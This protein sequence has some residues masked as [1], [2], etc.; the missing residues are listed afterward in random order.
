M[1]ADARRA[2]AVVATEANTAPI[3]MNL[4]TDA[5]KYYFIQMRESFF[6]LMQNPVWAGQ[7]EENYRKAKGILH[8]IPI[9]QWLKDFLED[10]YGYENLTIVPNGINTNM[11]YP[12]PAFPKKPDK[13]RVLIEGFGSSE[14]KDVHMM[15]YRAVD[16][17]RKVRPGTIELWG[18][19]QG[20]CYGDFDR[21][22][23]W[24]DQDLI[25]Q[26][27]SSSDVLITCKT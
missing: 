13:K 14:A 27:Y 16:R 24:P 17:Y 20:S 3:V 1:P 26:L 12:D 7:V 10:I 15:A 6:F 23:R 2:D 4:E 22:W 5:R 25:R 9:G 8:P 18:F 19:S 21:Y 11:F